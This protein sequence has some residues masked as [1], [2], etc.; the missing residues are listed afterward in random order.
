MISITSATRKV[1]FKELRTSKLFD[2]Q[3]R[4]SRVKT[5]DGGVVV[6]HSGVTD[7]D[8]TLQVK[9][10]LSDDQATSLKSIYTNDTFVN[11]AFSDGLFYGV[12][13]DLKSIKGELNMTILIKERDA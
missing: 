7:G 2:T 10:R 9:A 11:I 6:T 3:A 4:V 1:L 5:L 13:Q 8:R 12:I